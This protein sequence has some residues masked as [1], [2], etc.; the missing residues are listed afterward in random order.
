MGQ[1]N[2]AKEF[3]APEDSA[4]LVRPR[5]KNCLSSLKALLP[6]L[7]SRQFEFN[8]FRD[9]DVNSRQFEDRLQKDRLRAL[10]RLLIKHYSS[11]EKSSATAKNTKNTDTLFL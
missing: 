3:S 2:P 1:T 6:R 5:A 10:F 7:S 11:I 9:L 4:V 8:M